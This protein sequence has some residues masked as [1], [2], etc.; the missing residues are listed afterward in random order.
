MSDSK[1]D[2]ATRK[3]RFKIC[4]P[5]APGPPGD[6]VSHGRFRIIPQSMLKITTKSTFQFVEFTCVSNLLFTLFARDFKVPKR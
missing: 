1:N 4:P 3:G 2:D 6:Q 5:N